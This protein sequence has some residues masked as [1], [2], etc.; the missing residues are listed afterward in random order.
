VCARTYANSFHGFNRSANPFI[1]WHVRIDNGPRSA[2]HQAVVPWPC[3]QAAPMP[4]GRFSSLKMWPFSCC[5]G[6][7]ARWRL[8]CLPAEPLGSSTP[9]RHFE[10]ARESSY[11]SLY[12]NT[13]SRI[14]PY[15]PLLHYTLGRHGRKCRKNTAGQASSGTR[16]YKDRKRS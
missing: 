14:N 1:A 3:P 13:N 7:S 5:L 6:Q 11:N 2:P 8:P 4:A 15:I 16:A 9:L 12:Q 10:L